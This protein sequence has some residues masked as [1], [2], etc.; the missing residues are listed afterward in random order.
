KCEM[1]NL[2]VVHAIIAAVNTA[3]PELKRSPE[4]LITFVKDRPG[5]D[6]RYAIDCSKIERELGWSPLETFASGLQRT[7][8]W[9]VAN[10]AW[11]EEIQSGKYQ[12]QRLGAE[13]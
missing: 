11:M 6:R 9:Y 12:L 13:S 3:L 2:D 5:H 1:K 4:E 7:V 10:A 8:N